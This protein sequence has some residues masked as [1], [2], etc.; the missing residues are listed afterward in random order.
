MAK[1]LLSILVCLTLVAR[2]GRSQFMFW[3]S[4]TQEFSFRPTFPAN[5]KVWAFD[6]NYPWQSGVDMTVSSVTTSDNVW[7]MVDLGS[8]LLGRAGVSWNSSTKIIYSVKLQL[9]FQKY[10]LFVYPPP[11]PS[12][13]LPG[14]YFLPG[15]VIIGQGYHTPSVMA[16][17]WGHFWG[18]DDDS[19]NCIMSS[20]L[21]PGT[22]RLTRCA[23]EI[24][25]MNVRYPGYY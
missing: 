9:N 21:P 20:P 25:E 1:I 6:A 8:V 17:E 16:H 19:A 12:Q 10:N 23:N 24:Y 7:E 11:F 13:P 14:H 2:E 18:L 4:R 5:L 22:I 3:E 15:H